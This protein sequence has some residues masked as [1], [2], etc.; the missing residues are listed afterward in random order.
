LR[1]FQQHRLEA[2]PEYT[3]KGKRTASG[4][5]PIKTRKSANHGG[6]CSGV[7]VEKENSRELENAGDSKSFGYR[8]YLIDSKR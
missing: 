6:S 1:Q 2:H 4:K 8:Q 3:P 5:I 7:E